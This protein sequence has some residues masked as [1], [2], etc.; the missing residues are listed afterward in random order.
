MDLIYQAVFEGLGPEEKETYRQILEDRSKKSGLV[1][2]SV[3]L[4]LFSGSSN[5]KACTIKFTQK[6]LLLTIN[7]RNGPGLCF[8]SSRSPVELI[9][10][11]ISRISAYGS[12]PC[13]TSR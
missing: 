8:V 1:T 4:V 11:Q 3:L 2:L 6:L 7:W 5:N 9:W 13:V 10:W 12:S